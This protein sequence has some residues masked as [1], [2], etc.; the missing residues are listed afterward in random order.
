MRVIGYVRVSTMGQA[1]DGYGL[2]EQERAIR[3]WCK[4]NGHKLLRIERDEGKSGTLDV[5]E[6]P[7]LAEVMR[8]IETAEAEAV[9]IPALDRLARVLHVQEAA[10]QS[11]WKRG[12]RVFAADHGEV[13]QDDPDDPVR[14]FI[15]QVLGAAAQ[16]DR[17][18]II[19]KLR[20]GRAAKAAAAREAG[21]NRHAYGAPPYGKRAQGGRLVD[22]PDEQEV[23]ARIRELRA[24][25][26]SLRAVAEILA[27]EGH[28]PRNGGRWH[29]TQVRRLA[30]DAAREA[31]HAYDA[32]RPALRQ[33]AQLA[34]Q[35]A[36]EL[37]K[38]E[39]LLRAHGRL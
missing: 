25:G 7:G 10:L 19:K 16:L 15:R 13:M 36:A 23:I 4:D 9:V 14:T 11:V 6:R 20:N 26:R 39:A 3:A 37:A 33:A 22:D 32:K 27:A 34:E 29:P 1:T 28:A 18:M 17:G 21:D 12:G 8:A 31:D 38:A 5:H 24:A 35:H 2:A 30:D